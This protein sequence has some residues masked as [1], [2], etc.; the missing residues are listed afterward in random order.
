MYKSTALLK[1]L[2][3]WQRRNLFELVIEITSRCN[4]NCRHC[5]INSPEDDK[6]IKDTEMSL[7]KIKRIIDEAE[8]MGCLYCGLTG[9][10]PLLREDFIDIYLY[11][12]EKGFFVSVFSNATLFTKE[13]VDVF[14]KYPPR[15]IEV[16]VYGVT[17]DT[18][19][20]V[21][22]K[23]GSFRAFETGLDLLLRSGLRI[24]LKAMALRSNLHEIHQI[25][26]YC[27]HKTTNLYRFDPFLHLRY[28][29]NPKSNEGILNERLS[30]GEI[31]FLEQQDPER[32]R[33]VRQ[34]CQGMSHHQNR[35]IDNRIIPCGAGETGMAVSYYGKL[36]LCAS[37]NE[38]STVFDLDKGSIYQAWHE[39]VPKIRAL[40][41]NVSK[42]GKCATCTIIN[43]CYWCPAHAFL[44]V[45]RMDMS[46]DY[47]CEVAHAR[48]RAF[49]NK[50]SL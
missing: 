20:N 9:G 19:E 18:Y 46:V 29:F 24:R 16:S 11:L 12:K 1:D 49:M 47:F 42:T 22:R 17:R 25:G 32:S 45:G 7:G 8:S 33:A 50:G 38:P 37:L 3:I 44:E 15:V 6:A 30:P 41:S 21:T 14:L 39:F 26:A 43:L 2:P 35:M 40:R 5:Y 10:E 27:R 31:V 4:N 23:E 13:I 34:L 28:D 36:Q 48:A